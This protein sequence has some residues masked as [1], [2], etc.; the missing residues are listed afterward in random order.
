MAS[1][2]HAALTPLEE[3]VLGYLSCEVASTGQPNR[4]NGDGLIG[5]AIEKVAI[6]S[7]STVAFFLIET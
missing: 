2:L 6:H 7:A 4:K 5:R 1:S 3:K